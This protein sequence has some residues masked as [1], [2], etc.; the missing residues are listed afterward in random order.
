MFLGHV[1]RTAE[2]KAPVEKV[3]AILTDWDR[4]REWAKS[5]EKFEV[6]SKQRSGVGMTFREVG[7]I[8]GGRA[9]RYDARCDVIEF[10]ENKIIAWRVTSGDKWVR[11]GNRTSWTVKPTEVGA[12]LT[13]TSDYEVPYSIFGKIIDKLFRGR[14]EK[15]VDGWMENIKS[16][17]EK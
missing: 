2:I 9:Q 12:R 10:V 8:A 4:L 17:A 7:V 3:W 14:F 16:L 13:Y 6:T 15:Q 11:K 1:E 5:V